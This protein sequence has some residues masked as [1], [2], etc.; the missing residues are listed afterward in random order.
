MNKLKVLN[1]QSFKRK[2]RGR[3]FVFQT[4]KNADMKNEPGTGKSL[5]KRKGNLGNLSLYFLGFMT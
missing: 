3:S 4:W 5:H 2:L 1:Y